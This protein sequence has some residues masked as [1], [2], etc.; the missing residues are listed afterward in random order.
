MCRTGRAE[1][2]ARYDTIEFATGID[3]EDDFAFIACR[4][5]GVEIV[6]VSDVKNPK[7]VSIMRV[8][9]AQSCEVSDGYLYAGAW[10]ERRVAICDVRNPAAPK[11]VATVRLDGR[12]DGVCVRNGLSMRL[13]GTTSPGR[14]SMSTIRDTG[15]A[16]AWTS[17][18]SPIRRIRSICRE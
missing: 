7:H 6:D 13:L 11:Q 8:G 3:V 14:N 1:D 16:T 17:T 12:G 4:W 10:A 5:F 18:T 9:E 2:H 15:R